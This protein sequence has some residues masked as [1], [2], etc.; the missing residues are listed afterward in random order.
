VAA[1]DRAKAVLAACRAA[2]DQHA[3]EYARRID[4]TLAAPVERVVELAG[5]RPGVRLLDLA[6]GTGAVARA[7]TRR[8]ASV[9][10]VDVSEPMLAVAREFSPEI[11]FRVAD[12][13]GLPLP[14]GEFDVVN[15]A[16][17]LS[18]FQDPPKALGEVSRV[19]RRGGR[20]VASTWG[21]GGGTPASEKVVELLERYGA[22][23]KGYMLDEET[24]LD[25]DN[26]S[27]VLRRAGFTGMTVSAETFAGRFSDAEQALQWTLA[28]PFASARL[29]RIAG[30]V[31]DTFKTAA[32]RELADVDLSWTFVFNF[33]DAAKHR[34]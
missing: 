30:S 5:A 31:R 9:V 29:D 28:W 33:Y 15:C 8:G 13:H 23:D 22:R 4:P 18:H 14:D 19:L 25:P 7:A 12:A 2:Y 24:W 32:R 21:T 11:D 20:L 27:K 16:L 26:G 6:T 10:G 34:V 17:A 1:G 3:A